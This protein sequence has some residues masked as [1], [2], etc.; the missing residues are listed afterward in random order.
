MR[1]EG[2]FFVIVRLSGCLYSA[3]PI[4]P[5]KAN[6]EFGGP[7]GARPRTIFAVLDKRVS[8]DEIKDVMVEEGKE[9]HPIHLLNFKREEEGS[10]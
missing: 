1:R 5:T 6:G 9:E 3:R 10:R 7:P 4:H 8:E 2:V